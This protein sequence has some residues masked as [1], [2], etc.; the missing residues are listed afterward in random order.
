MNEAFAY[1]AEIFP[2]T[3]RATAHGISAAVRKLGAF[4]G[5]F[6]FPVLL[7]VAHLSGAM[8]VVALASLGGFLLTFFL[9]EPDRKSLEAIEREG[10]ERDKELQE[11]G[12]INW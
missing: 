2:V 8:G 3:V 4:V 12:L 6:L 10:R 1:P 9:P 5:A 11:F 7:S